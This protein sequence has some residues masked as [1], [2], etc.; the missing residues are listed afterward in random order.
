MVATP[1]G[2]EPTA[3]ELAAAVQ[4]KYDG[5]HSFTTDFTHSYRGDL[6][7]TLTHGTTTK[8]FFNKEG[9]SAD[10]LKQTFTLAD[11]SGAT[12]SGAWTIK[13]EDTEA[14]DTG[15]LN[16]WALEVTTR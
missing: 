9:G 12:L 13:V 11:F 5:I 4:K 10:D 2:A 7:V 8:V 6:K 16:S 15:K 3:S 14:Q 1:R